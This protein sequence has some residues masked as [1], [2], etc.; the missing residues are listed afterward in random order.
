MLTISSTNC[1]RLL[2]MGSKLVDWLSKELDQRGWSYRELARRSGL[3]NSTI[4][5]VMTGQRSATDA[6]CKKVG[7][8]LGYSPEALMRMAGIL[9]EIDDEDRLSIRELVEIVRRLP[10]D[11][12]KEVLNYALF[13]AKFPYAPD[14]ADA[15]SEPDRTATEPEL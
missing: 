8:A 7:R 1:G 13:R 12:L 4:S 15:A 11:A 2:T 9:P 6:F 14:S 3:S 5:N 10:K